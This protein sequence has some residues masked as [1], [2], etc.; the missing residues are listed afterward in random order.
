M[1]TLNIEDVS[2]KITAFKGKQVT[3]AMEMPLGV[4][5]VSGG[6][7]LNKP[8][9]SQQII[10]AL[11]ENRI[12]EKEVAA[13]ISGMHSIYRV[14]Y[15]PKLERKLL[16]EAARIE[17]EK[18]IPVPLDTLYT[19]WQDV[20]VSA[21]E[22][23]LCLIGLPRDNVDSVMETI[24]MCGLKLTHLELKPLAVSRVIDENS[25]IV[26]NVQ[27]NSFDITI[28]EGGIPEITRNLA[29]PD[30][31]LS[32]LDKMAVIKEETARTVYF[33]NSSH[34][35]KPLGEKTT[36]FLSGNLRDNLNQVIGYV[37]KPLPAYLTYPSGI[38]ENMYVANTGLALRY[39]KNVA[40][41]MRVDINV[42]APVAGV[43]PVVAVTAARPATAF[44]IRPLVAFL[45]AVVIV[46]SM[47]VAT[48][49]ASSQISGLQAQVTEKVKQTSDLQKQITGESDKL[50]KELDGD[51]LTLS[52][53]K[54]PLD[55]IAKQNASIN[56]DLGNAIAP[57]PGV[58]F[59]TAIADDG[60]TIT[61]SGLAPSGD[62]VLDY[63]RALWQSG[64][65]KLVLVTSMQSQDYNEV[66]FQIAITPNR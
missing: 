46:G 22:I 21:D 64:Q 14:V 6:I 27:E 1:L 38:D 47:F 8:L 23:A 20:K 9:V 16:A 13:C 39:M 51:K 58:M 49:I 50:K 41:P 34:T 24:K 61:V 15:V 54:T 45:I 48:Q 12:N 59:L 2:L 25:C 57:L 65:Y 42:M 10:R 60:T 33:Y 52:T 4:D 19:F 18:A 55:Y 62:M 35:E 7:V 66:K 63:A 36:C 26:I 5:W 37:L 29:F 31:A 43:K 30:S 40:R 53:L 17:M 56:R 3:F 44:Q 32:Y 11:T 28:I